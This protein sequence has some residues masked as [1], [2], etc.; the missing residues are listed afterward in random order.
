MSAYDVYQPDLCFFL[1]EDL[2]DPGLVPI[3]SLPAIGI[4]VLS[5]STRSVDLKEKLPQYAARGVPEY[6]VFDPVNRGFSLHLLGDDG[7]YIGTPVIS[8]PIP[9][10]LFKGTPVDLD[11]I[12]AP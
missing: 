5:P 2:P 7:T 8:G 6:W 4:E 10:G 3:T 1:P 12:F 9:V 11:A